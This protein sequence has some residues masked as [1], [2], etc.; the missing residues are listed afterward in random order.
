MMCFKLV[1]TSIL[2]SSNFQ[3]KL[4]NRNQMISEN[5]YYRGDGTVCIC[6]LLTFVQLPF[7]TMKFQWLLVR[8][9]CSFYF[10]EDYL[11]NL[12]AEAGFCIVDLDTHCR[13]VVNHSRNMTFDR[14]NQ[15]LLL[16]SIL[17]LMFCLTILSVCN[18]VL[19]FR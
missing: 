2:S 3:V 12:F 8:L 4:E 1:C 17:Y 7:D 19:V 13:Q 6:I 10:S 14:Y 15:I 16:L 18:F 11:S 9:Q 5:F